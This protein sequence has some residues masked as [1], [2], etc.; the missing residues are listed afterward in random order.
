MMFGMFGFGLLMML[1]VIGLPVLLLILLLGGAAGILQNKNQS[2]STNQDQ[3]PVYRPMLN[4][5]ASALASSRY[6]SHCGVGLQS[7]WTH[8][9]QCGAP[10]NG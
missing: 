2:V 4:S 5:N 10:I 7:D 8:C 6:C 3:S 1:L 9:P